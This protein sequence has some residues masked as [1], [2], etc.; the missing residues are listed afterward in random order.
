MKQL[1]AASGA[2]FAGNLSVIVRTEG[3]RTGAEKERKKRQIRTKKKTKA[4]KR[5]KRETKAKSKKR[6]GKKGSQCYMFFIIF[7]NVC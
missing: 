6:K 2:A 5:A 4:Q 7:L 1:V 3:K